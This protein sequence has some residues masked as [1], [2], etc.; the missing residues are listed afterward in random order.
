MIQKSYKRHAVLASTGF[1]MENHRHAPEVLK[2]AIAK[3]NVNS[4]KLTE[5]DVV[6]LCK[7]S[8]LYAVCVF[9]PK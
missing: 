6:S 8:L 1:Y 7:S 4:G 3:F 9:M 2:I 5:Y